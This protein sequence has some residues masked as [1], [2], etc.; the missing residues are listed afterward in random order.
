MNQILA[1]VLVGLKIS[2]SSKVWKL[3]INMLVTRKVFGP[4]GELLLLEVS[5]P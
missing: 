4:I 3:I 1:R 2:A 5:D